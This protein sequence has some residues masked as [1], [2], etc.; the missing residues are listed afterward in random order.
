[1]VFHESD[2]KLDVDRGR[3]YREETPG[4]ISDEAEGAEERASR[5]QQMIPGTGRGVEP[6]ASSEHDPRRRVSR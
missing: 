4:R 3:A 5:Q 2:E 6:V 1:M